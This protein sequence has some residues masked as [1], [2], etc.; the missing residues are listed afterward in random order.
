MVR[1]EELAAAALSGDALGLRALAAQFLAE[2]T[3]FEREPPPSSR[4]PKIR[5]VSA[6]LI[7]LF[8]ERAGTTAPNWSG[9]IGSAGSPLFLIA[10][11]AKMP[12]LRE[13]CERES[14]RPF[15]SRGIFVTPNYLESA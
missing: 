15:R 8:A 9:K 4:D 6:A 10:S 2:A 12:R 1:L 3:D 5:A 11:A 14:P 13:L 7:E